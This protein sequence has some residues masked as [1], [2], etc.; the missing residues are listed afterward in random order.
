MMSPI[1]HIVAKKDILIKRN[2]NINNKIIQLFGKGIE[3]DAL[4]QLVIQR[5]KGKGVA[6]KTTQQ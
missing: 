4:E 3:M 2:M 6:M 1:C 5:M